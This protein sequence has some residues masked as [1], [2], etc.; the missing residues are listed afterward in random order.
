[1]AY[2]LGPSVYNE[3]YTIILCRCLT[4][5]GHVCILHLCPIGCLYFESVVPTSHSTYTSDWI[6]MVSASYLHMIVEKVLS[7]YKVFF[8]GKVG[9]I[10]SH[11]CGFVLVSH[12]H[13]LPEHIG[14]S[15]KVSLC[16]CYLSLR[17]Y[18]QHCMCRTF[19]FTCKNLFVGLYVMSCIEGVLLQTD[20]QLCACLALCRCSLLHVY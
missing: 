20:N 5:Y 6:C 14:N 1:M 7:G 18:W 2:S 13:V 16:L 3:L 10:V 15:A 4:H 9:R 11:R 17:H 12:A 19:T 8:Y